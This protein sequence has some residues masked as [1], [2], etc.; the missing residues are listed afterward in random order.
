M[1]KR[2]KWSKKLVY[3]AVFIYT[4]FSHILINC[5]CNNTLQNDQELRNAWIGKFATMDAEQLVFLDESAA[6]E[7]SAH[8]KYGWA[9]VGITPHEYKSIKRSER[10]SILPAYTADGFITWEFIQ[11]S[12]STELFNDF[13]EFNLLPF[14]N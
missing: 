3:L 6:N 10:W 7:R 13:I 2:V 14:C 12:Y 9:H 11:G 4:M 5:R 8:R 1:L